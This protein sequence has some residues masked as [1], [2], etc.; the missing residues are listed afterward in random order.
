MTEC[1]TLQLRARP[2][3]EAQAVAVIVCKQH[4]DLLARRDLKKLAAATG[5][6][7][8]LLKAAQNKKKK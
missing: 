1:L 5:A 8:D 6:E 4:L 7:E 3:C 2:R